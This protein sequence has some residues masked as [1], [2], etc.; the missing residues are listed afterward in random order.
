MYSVYTVNTRKEKLNDD[1]K[2]NLVVS[3]AWLQVLK[4]LFNRDSHERFKLLIYF[5]V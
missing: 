5:I 1:W 3:D 4:E 2:K